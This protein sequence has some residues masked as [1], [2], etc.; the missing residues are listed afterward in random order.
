[1]NAENKFAR[2]LRNS[3]PAR[4]LVPIG[5]IL[6]IFGIILSCFKS[7]NFVETVG[8]ITA[9]REGTYDMETEQQQYDVD[10]TYDVDGKEYTNSFA[11]LNGK[12]NVG[13]EIK[14]YYDP[15]DPAKTTNSKMGAWLGPVMIALGVLAAAFGIFK[16]V[17][18]FQK[19]KELDRTAGAFPTEGFEAL[20][21]APGTTEYYF[22]F[23]GNTFKPGYI[24]E[25]AARNVL[26]EGKMVKQA[27]VG[28]RVF[29]LNDHT[30]GSVSEHEVGHTTSQSFNDEF[31]SMKS[32]FKY[33]GENIWD[34]LHNRGLRMATDLRSKFP[35]LSYN[36][37]KN[38]E[39]FARIETTS[40]YVHEEDEAQHAVKIPVGRYYYRV[41]TPS[42]DL[43][44]IFLTV[45]AISETEQTMVE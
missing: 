22:S 18:A 35:V 15:A 7:D 20:K 10:F 28:A 13:D 11:D 31:F 9:V 34:V 16:T 41:W 37:A 27:I 45:F 26:F 36:V 5:I 4:V 1:M 43:E 2:F 38:G 30:T 32:W 29:E 24:V 19:S 23:D 3:G 25:D 44:T 6:I 12:F 33:D 39:P 40:M 42:K 14:V 21:S 8:R 17:K